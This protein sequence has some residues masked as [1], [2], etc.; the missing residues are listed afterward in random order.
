MLPNIFLFELQQRLR[1]ISTW[2]YFVVFFTLGCLFTLLSGGAFPGGSVEFGTGGKVLINSPYALNSIITYISFFGIVI[3][4]A[5]AGQATYQDIDSNSTPFFY[6]APISKLDYL[7]GRFLAAFA[8]QV[9]IFASVGL[10][11]WVGTLMPWIDKTRLG[12]QMA[13]AYFQP[14]FINVW[15]NLL[16]L[17]AIFFALAAL[18]RKMLPVYVASVLVLIGYSAVEQLSG[19][20]LT[21]SVH[22]ALAD[23]LG[24]AAID[25]LTRY[26]TPFQRNTQLIPLQ[27]ILLEN[28]AL[29]LAVGAVFFVFTYVKFAFAYSAEKSK[30]REPVEEKETARPADSLPIAHPSFSAAASF[31]HLVSLTRIQFKETTKNVFFL[32]LML[33]GFLFSVLSAAGIDNP[34]APRTWPLTQQMVLMAG[35]GFSIFAIAIIIF[36]SGELVWRERD[37]QLNQVMDALPLQRWVLFCSKLLALMLVP[38]IVVVLILVSGLVVQ[39]A[40][41]YYHF[42]FGL[43]LRELFLNR[44]TSLWI[45]CVLAIF[46]QTIVNNKYLGH[47]VM[48]LYIIATLALPPAGFQDYLY[49]FGQTPQVTYSDINGYG[50]FLQPLIWFRIYWLVAAVLLA[51]LTNL[52]WVRGTESSWRVRMSLARARLSRATLAGAA[53]S[54]ALLLG[55]GSYIFYNTH[56]LNPYRTTFRIDGER[57][58][59][60]KKYRQ[61]WALPQPRITDVTTEID[62]Y[63]EQRSATISGTMWMENKT[64]SDI[65]R[66]AV[67]LW[68]NNVPPLPP[69]P[70]IQ[71]KKLG[72][73]GGATTLVEDPSVG[74]YLF[75]LPTPLPPHG[76]IQLDFALQ[77]DSRGF[78]NSQP[79]IDLVHNGSFVYDSYL[80]YIGYSPN[81]ELTDDST[82]RKHGLDKPRRLPTLD[83]LAARQY[84]SGS[85][86]A[87]WIKFD[88][89]VSTSEDQIA[90]AP[91]YLQ[92]EW[93]ENGRRY[94]HYKMDAPIMNIY[95]IQSAR[96]AVRRDK[97]NDVNLEIYYQPG[98]EFNLDTMMQSM[99]E[100]LAYCTTNF[101]P[102]QF[103]Q[104]RII[105]FPGYASFAESFANTIPFSE[106]IGFTTKISKKPDAVNLPFYVTAHE[107]GHQWWGHQVMSAYVQGAT[108]I[109]ETMAQ[110]TALMVMKHHFGAESMQRFLRFELDQYLRGRAQ[111]RNQEFPLYL[112]DPNQG[113]I[114]YNKGAMVMYSLQDYIGEDKVNAAI[115]EFLKSHAF[116]D[117]PYPTSLELES[118][119]QKVTPP[120]YQYLFDDMFRNIT[121]YDDRA[122]SA[123]YVKRADGKYDVHLV[124]EAKKFRADGRGQE[125]AVPVNDF[126]DIGVLD[127][128]GKYLYLDRRKID[129]EK[130]DLT[131]TVDKVPAQAG[132]DPVDKLIDRNPDDN[133][134]AVKKR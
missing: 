53:V 98:H 126:M 118:Y 113:Y 93:V 10:G 71:V 52:L 86:D 3:T 87:D 79:N 66:I 97:W 61:Y 75:K 47:F 43:Y 29:W 37:A 91:G 16:F 19:S 108:S 62:I 94:F 115:R 50:P 132:I 111:E 70:P 81:I 26:W 20:A 2:V 78:P 99:K 28:R 55:A 4:A 89:T 92:K 5:I 116:K 125:H 1:R 46:V 25:R 17:T 40:Q 51:I 77:Y 82:R 90:I 36:Y 31:Q 27:G 96:Y 59:Y 11:A 109:D 117:G 112:V 106:R 130:T 101:S 22:F 88:A 8:V 34:L 6:T 38:V 134:I 129:Q 114:H 72:F 9:P 23:P 85:F 14:Y 54:V 100:T 74:F 68:P 131:I 133:V 60:E 119:F 12:P 80:P 33:A 15:P 127:A 107:T 122:L 30:R 76:R 105:E 128:D 57:A 103:H 35:A 49:R 124:V 21:T 84:N 69:R 65:D 39:I 83:D 41:G 32:V 64:A 73:V 24:S 7:G 56:V 123:D 48:V 44:L 104:L 45:L 58:Q 63:P 67:T 18:S 120:Q 110:Y 121:I 95:S 42:E 102:F 13:A